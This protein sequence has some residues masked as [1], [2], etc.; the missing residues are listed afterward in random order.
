MPRILVLVAGLPRKILGPFITRLKQNNATVDVLE[1]LPLDSGSYTPEY[2]E[3]L[4]RM[5]GSELRGTGGA[6]S[7]AWRGLNFIVLFLRKPDGSEHHVVERFDMEALLV[8]LAMETTTRKAPKRHR[9]HVIVNAL[10]SQSSKLL[11]HARMVLSHLAEEVT[12][13]DSRTCVLLPRANFGREFETVRVCVQG[14]VEGFESRDAFKRKLKAAGNRL[15]KSSDGRFRSG[16][17]VFWAPSKA[18]ARHGLAPLW[19]TKGHDE[20]CVIRGHVR[21][22]VPY[23][24]KFHYDCDLAGTDRR[25]FTSCHGE[26]RL[27]RGRSH[28]NIA[29][30]DNIR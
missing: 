1:T 13:R 30:N 15:A 8:P 7:G 11:R 27:R 21:F 28:V 3:C 16:Q 24:P 12:N 22:G 26:T 2:A 10:A 18:G 25:S 14:A 23:D 17:L 29:P 5:L 20:R 19:N 6:G 9:D 4:Y